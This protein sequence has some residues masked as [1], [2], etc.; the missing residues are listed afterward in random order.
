MLE[1][2]YMY[3]KYFLGALFSIPLLPI[4]YFDGKRIKGSVPK[5]PEAEGLTGSSQA[6]HSLGKSIKLLSIGESTIAGVGVESHAEGFTGT[7]AS[8][9]SQQ[10]G[11]KVDWRVYARS[12]YTAQRVADRILPKIEEKEADL[13][14]VGLGGNDAFTLN[15]PWKWGQSVELLIQKLQTQF[16]E[17][18]IVFCN[19]PPIKEFPAFTPVIKGTVGNLVEIL[20][21]TLAQ[22]VKKYPRVYYAEEIITI[23]GWAQRYQQSSDTKLYFSDGVHPSK[24]TYQIWAKDMAQLIANIQ[25]LTV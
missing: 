21:E 8:E 7:L 2:A 9:L 18:L 12:G 10:L 20:G 25:E 17:S 1:S 19:M 13:I 4:M 14:V 11:V 24:I 22:V 16:P 3:L 6:P 5:L 15:R 23:D